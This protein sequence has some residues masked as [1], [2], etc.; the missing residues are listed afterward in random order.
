[1]PGKLTVS[2][3]VLSMWTCAY[4]QWSMGTS[5]ISSLPAA[6]GMLLSRYCC[7]GIS[8]CTDECRISGSQSLNCKS[9]FAKSQT[10]SEITPHSKGPGESPNAR[11]RVIGAMS[12]SKIWVMVCRATNH[13]V[14]PCGKLICNLSLMHILWFGCFLL[15][16]T[17]QLTRRR[18]Q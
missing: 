4:P 15:T 16:S 14:S 7:V 5:M 12:S 10:V 17:A 18:M 13:G 2:P 3:T 11:Q 6:K 1:M 8:F 9:L